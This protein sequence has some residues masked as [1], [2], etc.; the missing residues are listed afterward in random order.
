M[1]K[2]AQYK[3]LLYTATSLASVLAL[4]SFAQPVG[5]EETVA[6]S[7]SQPPT[8]AKSPSSSASSTSAL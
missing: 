3:G 8:S 1:K 2:Q 7:N 5:A 4:L 6:P